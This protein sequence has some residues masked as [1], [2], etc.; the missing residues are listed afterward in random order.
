MPCYITRD[1]DGYVL[2]C[3]A[4]GGLPPDA[5]GVTIKVIDEAGLD[6]YAYKEMGVKAELSMLYPRFIAATPGLALTLMSALKQFQGDFITITDGLGVDYEDLI[7]EAAR[8]TK[9]QRISGAVWGDTDYPSG[10]ELTAV[11]MV[12][13]V[14]AEAG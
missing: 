9:K 1:I 10:I 13:Y 4:I 12:R 8:I 7:L 14:G 3:I 6:G 11:L 5:G 2:P